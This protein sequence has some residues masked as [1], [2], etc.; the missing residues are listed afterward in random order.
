MCGGSKKVK[1]TKE[2]RELARI[3]LERWGRYKS[4]Y[5]PMEDR[6]IKRT[7]N[8]I[9]NPSGQAEGMANVSTQQA[10]SPVEGQVTAGLTGRGARSGSGAFIG[11]LTGL[12]RDRTTSSVSSQVAARGLQQRQG[13][14]NLQTLIGMGQ[15]QA[16]GAL[17]GMAGQASAANRQAIMDSRASAAA[18]SAMLQIAGTA[19]GIGY[20]M[21]GSPVA[22]AT[23][24]GN[25]PNGNTFQPT[26]P[27]PEG[28]VMK[29]GA[30][31]VY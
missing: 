6:L 20:G 12:N 17:E 11:A 18:R 10:F 16:G 28:S 19:A 4:R 30:G 3:G 9:D 25:I 2:E 26:Q 15:G 27:L 14:T 5:V 7:V 1:P 21:Y 8:S 22:G 29:G 23:P 31:G 13:I 24:N